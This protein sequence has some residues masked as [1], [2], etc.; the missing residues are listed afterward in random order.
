VI[1]DAYVTLY[2]SRTSFAVDEF[3]WYHYASKED[4]ARVLTRQVFVERV[5]LACPA[6]SGNVSSIS[7]AI[8]AIE[9]RLVNQRVVGWPGLVGLPQRPLASQKESQFVTIA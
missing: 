9:D 6:L 5:Q 7:C 3:G 2:S 1:V 4:K 8:P